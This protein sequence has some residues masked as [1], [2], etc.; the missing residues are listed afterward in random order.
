MTIC[1][2]LG[3]CGEKESRIE[4]SNPGPCEVVVFD[5]RKHSGTWKGLGSAAQSNPGPGKVPTDDEMAQFS[6]VAI[7]IFGVLTCRFLW[8]TNHIL[9]LFFVLTRVC[10]FCY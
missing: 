9:I 3:K 7:L 4:Y 10:V 1:T 5:S 6:F 8:Q 2:G